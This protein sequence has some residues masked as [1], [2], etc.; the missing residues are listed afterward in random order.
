MTKVVGF[1]LV[2]PP[3]P[4]YNIFSHLHRRSDIDKMSKSLASISLEQYNY[5]VCLQ[6]R[7]IRLIQIHPDSGDRPLQCSIIE[8]VIDSDVSFN[9]VSYVWGDPTNVQPIICNGRVLMVTRNLFAFLRR[10]RESGETSFLWADAICINQSDNKE[11]TVQVRMMCEIYRKAKSV[12]AWLGEEEEHDA[13][14]FD[15]MRHVCPRKDAHTREDMTEDM[16]SWR[17]FNE[18]LSQYPNI[19]KAS[20]GLSSLWSRPWF[21]RVW[22]VQEMVV[23]DNLTFRSGGNAIGSEIFFRGTLRLM[24]S[25]YITALSVGRI[26][27]PDR[28]NFKNLIDIYQIR[29]QMR[30]LEA[31]NSIYLIDVVNWTRSLRATDP[32]DKIYA[33]VGLATDTSQDYIDYENSL[34]EVLI[35]LAKSGFLDTRRLFISIDPIEFL[36]FAVTTRREVGPYFLPSWVPPFHDYPDYYTPLAY[37]MFRM[38]LQDL[39]SRPKFSFRAKDSLCFFGSVCDKIKITIDLKFQSLLGQTYGAMLEDDNTESS[40]QQP[41]FRDKLLENLAVVISLCEERLKVVRNMESYPTGEDPF[42]AYWR[43]LIC[44]SLKPALGWGHLKM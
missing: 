15:L 18:N 3:N 38:R 42:D 27:P 7:R 31:E 32:R 40:V 39:L 25:S 10:V 2:S 29:L 28:I 1:Q 13:A 17:D 35:R 21:S 19:V 5:G 8:A 44:N 24:R 41:L 12:I 30:D 26:S 22:I 37:C 16:S 36:S 34:K 20:V 9:A 11:K 14:A 43:T 6:D 4:S 23:T 33:L